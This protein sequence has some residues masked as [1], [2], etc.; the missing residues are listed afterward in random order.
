MKEPFH[1]FVG[2]FSSQKKIG[3]FSIET[4]FVGRVLQFLII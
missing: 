3:P 2:D 4:Y 1:I